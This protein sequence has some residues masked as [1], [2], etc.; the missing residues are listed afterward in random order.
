V[1]DIPQGFLAPTYCLNNAYRMSE[2]QLQDVKRAYFACITQIDYQLGLLFAR[3]RE[4]NLLENTWIVFTSDHGEMLGDHHMSAKTVFLEG[5]AHVPLIIRPPHSSWQRHARAGERVETLCQLADVMPSILAMAGLDNPG[6]T[7]GVDLMNLP[8]Q[9]AD[10][11]F[12]GACAG[13]QYAILQ[14]RI[15]YCFATAGGGELLFDLRQ[16]PCELHNLI[17]DPSCREVL[18]S[19]RAALVAKLAQFEPERLKDGR[20]R[21]DAPIAGPRDVSKWPGYHSIGV[22]TDVL[23]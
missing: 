14:D 21:C 19:L 4:M 3:L 18:Q 17:G 16:D 10:R 5:S 1:G 11:P 22:P 15:K 2:S 20:I 7:D 6:V 9:G 23:H 13:Q 12:F 8:A